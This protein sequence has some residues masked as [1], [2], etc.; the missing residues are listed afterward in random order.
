MSSQGSGRRLARRWWRTSSS[1]KSLSLAVLC[2][3]PLCCPP[4]GSRVCG[5][6]SS[7]LPHRSLATQEVG[8]I[9]QR[10]AAGTIK[11]VTLELGGKSPLIVCEDAD[12]DAAVE[13]AHNGIF[14]NSGQVCCAGSR[15]FVHEKV[16]DAFVAKSIL[17]AKARTV[18]D[19]FSGA[20]QGPQVSKE[21]LDTVLGYIAAGKAEG[22][23]LAVGGAQHGSVGYFVQVRAPQARPH[24][25]ASRRAATHTATPSPLPLLQPTIFTDVVDSMRIAREE[26]FGPCMAVLKWRDVEEVI[27]RANNSEYGLASAVLTKSLDLAMHISAGLRAGVVWVNTFNILGCQTPFGGY[28]QSGIGRELGEYVLANYYEVKS[29]IIATPTAAKNS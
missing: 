6:S 19:A 2:V 27:D 26:I 5:H 14:F 9:I 16:Y 10:E 7:P 20:Q 3:L 15:V 18:G 13:T 21:Q 1:T 29:V 8:R 12:I 17:L 25:C 11:R 4:P 23:T 22:A 24:A 28:K